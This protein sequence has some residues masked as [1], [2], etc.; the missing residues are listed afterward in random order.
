M[1]DV[2]KP[3]YMYVVAGF[4]GSPIKEEGEPHEGNGVDGR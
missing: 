2:C 3:V 1:P 4:Y